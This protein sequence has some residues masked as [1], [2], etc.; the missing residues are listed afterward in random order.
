[1][2]KYG[3]NAGETAGTDYFFFI[4]RAVGLAELRVTLLGNAAEFMI[5]WQGLI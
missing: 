5:V 3:R 4:E 2:V 1:M